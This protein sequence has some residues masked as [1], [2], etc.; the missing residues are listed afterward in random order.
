MYISFENKE[1]YCNTWL[2]KYSLSNAFVY[3]VALGIA[4]VNVIVKTI[5]RSKTGLVLKFYS[6]I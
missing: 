6:Y 1:T 5:L 4:I 3:L 2:E